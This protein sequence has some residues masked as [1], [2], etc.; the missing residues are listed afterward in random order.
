MNC[1]KISICLSFFAIILATTAT[2][3]RAATISWGSAQD[4][5]SVSDIS[6]A[7]TLV[8]AFNGGENS[9]TAAGINFAAAN[10]FG[11]ASVGGFLNSNTGDTGFNTLL[12]SASFSFNG[13]NTGN[14]G[15]IDLGSF[16]SGNTYQVQVFFTDQR[17]GAT[18]DRINQIGSTDTSGPGTTVDLESDPNNALSAPYGQFAVG[19]FVADGDDPDLTVLGTNFAS[20]QINGW[21]VRNVVPEPTTACLLG[22]VAAAF[23][24]S[25]NRS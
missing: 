3:S 4:T 25:R 17:P 22:L 16:A 21:Q 18:A 1:T 6:T 23:V 9:V 11:F 5:T 19:T 10:P 7:G 15:T 24:V 14:S 13:N 12:N 8:A 20:A 2:S